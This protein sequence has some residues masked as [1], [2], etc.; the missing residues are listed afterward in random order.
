MCEYT[1]SN[2]DQHCNHIRPGVVF[3][4]VVDTMVNVMC[5]MHLIQYT[6]QQ[7]NWCELAQFVNEI[8]RRIV[9]HV[10]TNPAT[11]IPTVTFTD[12]LSVYI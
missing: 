6:R 2:A 5:D 9:D 3:Q 7:P 10:P 4:C 11:E 1:F 8:I 12:L